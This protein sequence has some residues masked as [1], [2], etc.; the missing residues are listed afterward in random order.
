[1]LV[2]ASIL[3]NLRTLKK[4]WQK[5]NIEVQGISIAL[6]QINNNDYVSL[7]DIAKQSKKRASMLIA[8]WMQNQ[9]TLL[10]LEEWET[11]HNPNFK[12]QQMQS[13][14]LKAVEN[15]YKVTPQKYIKLTN[16]IGLISKSGRY[17][18]TFAHKEIALNFCYWLS[19][20]FQVYL[21]K[22]FN[23]LMKAEHERNNLEWHISK[24]TDNIDEVRNL[25]DTIPHQNPERN[26]FKNTKQ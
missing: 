23:E 11:L 24:I 19:P 13:F 5:K 6:D 8:T 16:A 21:F 17:G 14:R 15:R 26:R 7:T 12:G 2:F 20:K 1:M 10:Y 18:G 9:S 22:A 3:I 4:V 25:L